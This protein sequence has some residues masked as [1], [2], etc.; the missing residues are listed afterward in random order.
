[1]KLEGRK[2]VVRGNHPLYGKCYEILS[3]QRDHE[4]NDAT[5]LFLKTGDHSVL[6]VDAMNVII[7]GGWR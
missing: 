2:A 4:T 6:R 1:M 3:V 5:T 7:I